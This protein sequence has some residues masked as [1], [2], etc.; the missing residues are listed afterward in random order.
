[1]NK[2]VCCVLGVG[3]LIVG[4]VSMYNIN[5]NIKNLNLKKRQDLEDSYQKQIAKKDAIIYGQTQIID[6]QTNLIAV[7]SSDNKKL[8]KENN[9]L[10]GIVNNSY[11]IPSLENYMKNNDQEVL[12]NA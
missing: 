3:G 10:N 5:K 9:T 1:M 11:I 6:H 12:A 4:G 2:A 8:K 7:L